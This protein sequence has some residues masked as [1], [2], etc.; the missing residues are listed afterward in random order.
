VS[1]KPARN[2]LA[3]MAERLTAAVARRRERKPAPNMKTINLALQGGGAHGAFTWGVLDKLIEDG[4]LDIE[5]IS[6]T[7][8]G[9]MNA[10]VLAD[11]FMRD[12]GDGARQ[13]LREFWQ[14]V[15]ERGLGGSMGKILGPILSF[16]KLP[17]YPGLSVFQDF[18]NFTSPYAF[19]PLN[20]NPLRDLLDELVDFERVRANTGLRLYIS[21][22][23]VRDG[24][25]KVFSGDEVT[26]DAVMAS[27]CLPWLFKAVEIGGEHYWDGGFTGNPALFPFFDSTV[28][29]DILL[30]QVNPIRREDVPTTGHEIMER[31][32]EI[33]FN[34]SLLRE[35]RAID[36]VNRLMGENR[37]ASG[38]YR[39]NRLHRIDAT[40]ALADHTASSK[41]DT[42]WAFFT[43]LH[44]AGREAAGA[45]LRRH[46][47]DVG[48]K[49][50]LDLRSE[51]V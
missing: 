5:A 30:V 19:N 28:S 16:W 4:R 20:I 9:A 29:E 3:G 41:M 6:G 7:S 32:G 13:R 36:F 50:T 40:K 31:V 17:A 23:N 15:S 48:V 43:E 18:V 22:T 26:A 35:F 21:A 10:A 51:F 25:I 8:A 37:L 11:G 27:A 14:G 39:A 46:Y 45:W 44:A 47:D 2:G 24:K 1:D 42:S 49:G 33:T 38:R 12:G 34:E